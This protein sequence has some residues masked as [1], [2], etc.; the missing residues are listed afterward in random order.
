[1][2]HECTVNDMYDLYMDTSA[3]PF[4]GSDCIII[5]KT[6]AGL[7]QVR[8]KSDRRMV[9]SVPLKNITMTDKLMADKYMSE[10]KERC[11]RPCK[12]YDIRHN[13]IHPHEFEFT[14][15]KLSDET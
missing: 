2:T 11:G 5:K 3:R 6:K 8:L 4:I 1:M 10:L 13:Q 14:H 12:L 15:E 7:I 9:I